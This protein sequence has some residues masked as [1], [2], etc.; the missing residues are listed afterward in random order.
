MDANTRWQKQYRGF[1]VLLPWFFLFCLFFWK[2]CTSWITDLFRE[3]TDGLIQRRAIKSNIVGKPTIQ[4]ANPW[5][6]MKSFILLTCHF[7][8][9][10]PWCSSPGTCAWFC[11]LMWDPASHYSWEGLLCGGTMI[12]EQALKYHPILYGLSSQFPL[13]ALTP[14]ILTTSFSILLSSSTALVCFWFLTLLLHIH[15][16][17]KS[18]CVFF[19][20]LQ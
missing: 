1:V 9:K 11:S 3:W 10:A 7:C 20:L 18:C 8:I 15:S 4:I 17:A 14:Y 12:L 13:S 2:N 19:P 5:K 16:V 6:L